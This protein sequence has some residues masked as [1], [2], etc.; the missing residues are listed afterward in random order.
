[1]GEWCCIE[2]EESRVRRRADRGQEPSE[3]DSRAKPQGN[4]EKR[5]RE[6]T[7]LMLDTNL[8]SVKLLWPVLIMRW[9]LIPLDSWRVSE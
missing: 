4:R 7:E 5:G 3:G 8:S 1:M 9:L 2:R 6:E